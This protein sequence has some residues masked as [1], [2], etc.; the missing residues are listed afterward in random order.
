MR[1]RVA[2]L[3]QLPLD[4]QRAVME[5]ALL[6]VKTSHGQMSNA[7][8]YVGCALSVVVVSW[9]VIA[10][11]GM[12]FAILA[13]APAYFGSLLVGFFMWRR[14]IAVELQKVIERLISTRGCK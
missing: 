2:E 10:G 6:L 5:E 3:D 13:G 1:I 8:H 11:R 12:F 14:S 9:I 7:A 4:Q